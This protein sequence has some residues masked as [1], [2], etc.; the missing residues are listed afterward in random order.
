MTQESQQK[1]YSS[2]LVR[3]MKQNLPN[4]NQAY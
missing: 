3:D 1:N 2:L 4:R